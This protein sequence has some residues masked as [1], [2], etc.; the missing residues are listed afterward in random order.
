MKKIRTSTHSLF[1]RP[2]KALTHWMT[3]LLIF[4]FVMM[5][6]VHYHPAV[7]HFENGESHLL[8]GKV[9]V[10]YFSDDSA[11]AGEHG[12]SKESG[13][14]PEIKHL[15]K[16]KR[17]KKLD[18]FLTK[19]TF[20]EL[21]QIQGITFLSDGNSFPVTRKNYYLFPSTVSPPVSLA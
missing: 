7:Q 21:S 8:E 2:E 10:L 11:T 19:T 6:F 1:I 18:F 17:A 15:F 3:S 9:D 5:P 13:E 16:T 20:T 14:A 12:I 4:S